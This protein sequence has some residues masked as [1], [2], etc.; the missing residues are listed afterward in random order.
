[1]YPTDEIIFMPPDRMIGE[2][3]AFEPYFITT[4]FHQNP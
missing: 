1:M 4:K 3:I 2:P